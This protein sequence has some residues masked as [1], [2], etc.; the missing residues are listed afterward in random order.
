MVAVIHAP[1]DQPS[2]LR[3]TAG[4][5][6]AEGA[7]VLDALRRCEAMYG[8]ARLSNG[9]PIMAHVLGMALIVTGLELDADTRIA[10]L[11]LAHG[12]RELWTADRDFTRYPSLKIRNPLIAR[13]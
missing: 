5:G 4:L 11:C 3:L 6:E 13:R 2:D 8:P 1:S 7:R 12:V 9:E 10:A